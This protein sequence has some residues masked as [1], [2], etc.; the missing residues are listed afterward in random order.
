MVPLM[1]PR[2]ERISLAQELAHQ[3]AD[4]GNTTADTSLEEQVYIVVLGQRY[5]LRPML[6]H[7]LFVGGN[8]MFAPRQRVFQVP[9]SGL[10]AADDFR[11]DL[12]GGIV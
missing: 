1:M 7:R 6:G 10:I 8:H 9:C 4:D 12:N 3:A 2:M 5:Q 11:N